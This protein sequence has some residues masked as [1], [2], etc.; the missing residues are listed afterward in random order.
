MDIKKHTKLWFRYFWIKL[1]EIHEYKFNALMLSMGFII[2]MVL[3][4]FFWQVLLQ[5]KPTFHGWTLGELILLPI[6]LRIVWGLQS[7][8]SMGLLSIDEIILDGDLDKLLARPINT[9]FGVVSEYMQVWELFFGGVAG[10][11]LLI[12]VV[13]VFQMEVTLLGILSSIIIALLGLIIMVLTTSI[14]AISAFWIG[15]VESLM[16]MIMSFDK[17]GDYPLTLFPMGFQIFFVFFYPLM[18]VTVWPVKTLLGQIS[19]INT[20][21]IIIGG[22][23]IIT[24]WAFIFNILWKKGIK[25]YESG[26][27]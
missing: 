1:K 13:I 24:I 9:F 18:F 26:N 14:L 10:I 2:Q 3:W 21:G 12:L 5:S 4:I 25:R 27:G 23:V 15:R 17:F 16:N 8:T 7:L 6:F 20:I 19:L 22:I 11:I